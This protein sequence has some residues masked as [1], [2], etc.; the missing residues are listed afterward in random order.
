MGCGIVTMTPLRGT[1]EG[2]EVMELKARSKR[3]ELLM[4]VKMEAG[5]TS[6]AKEHRLPGEAGKGKKTI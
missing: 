1:Q 3:C 6:Q 4:A 2:S 5:T